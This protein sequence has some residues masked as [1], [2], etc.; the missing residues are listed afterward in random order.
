MK[1]T[2]VRYKGGG[3]D[4]CFW[5]WNYAYFDDGGKFHDIY[6]SGCDGLPEEQQVLDMLK[7]RNNDDN[8]EL[9]NLN[10]Q[11]DRDRLNEINAST[12]AQI[13]RWLEEHLGKELLVRCDA[14]K[15]YV[16]VLE[17]QLT[18]LRDE[19]GISSSHH[20]K[21]CNDC[22]CIKVCSGCGEYTPGELQGIDE[23]GCYCEWCYP[24]KMAEIAPTCKFCD[25]NEYKDELKLTD[26][27]C[28]NCWTDARQDAGSR[29]RAVIR[30]YLGEQHILIIRDA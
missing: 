2:L 21:V 11:A 25:G 14:C 13:S 29:V 10:I 6:S 30:E 18:D 23:H 4:G 24:E 27:I 20:G 22:Y 8:P 7:H 26:G 19:G 9:F 12:V 28:E 15:E 3:Y 17:I 5:E 1:N 16:D